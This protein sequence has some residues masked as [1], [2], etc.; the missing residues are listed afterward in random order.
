[1]KILITGSTGMVGRKLVETLKNNTG[2]RV[3]TPTHKDLDLINQEATQTYFKAHKP[4]IIFHC[5]SKVGGIQAN[6]DEPVDFLLTNMMIS[7]NVIHA[8]L[9]AGVERF[10][11]LGSSCMY[12]RDRE[13]L[14]EE[15]ILTGKLEPTNEGY[16]IAKNAAACLC[17]YIS[18]EYGLAYRTVIPPNL[19]GPYDHFDLVN[20]HLLPAVIL[21]LHLAKLKGEKIVKIWGD[22][23]A[24]REFLYIADL[25]DF[26]VVMLN[27]I[28]ELPN[29]INVGVGEDYTIDE[30]Y[31]MTAKVIGYQ[32]AFE[33]D[34]SKPVGMRKKLMDI[35]HVKKFGWQAKIPLD[36]GLKNTYHYF[37]KIID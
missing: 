11:N 1:M 37:L 36:E 24:R 3:L 13:I 34:F 30:Y 6:L 18:N 10:L 28:E 22:G 16:A 14:R 25:I 19:Y 23:Q 12:P 32:G 29:M 17:R 7:M 31:E 15:D 21:K 35:S 33:H 20:S 4:D 9:E 26:L 5:A 8:A 2:H 27:R